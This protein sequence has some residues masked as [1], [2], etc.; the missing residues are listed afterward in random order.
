MSAPVCRCN[1]P[2]ASIK[3]IRALARAVDAASACTEDRSET[4]ERVSSP[5][6]TSVINTIRVI[7]RIRVNPLFREL[8]KGRV[9]I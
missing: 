4:L 5:T 3:D 9:F 2:I 1:S 7:V 8:S 6:V